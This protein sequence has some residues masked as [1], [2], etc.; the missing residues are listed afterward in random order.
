MEKFSSLQ[1]GFAANFFLAH[2]YK[3][4]I[5]S[6]VLWDGKRFHEESSA[7]LNIFQKMGFPYSLAT[8]SVII[9]EFFRIKIYKYIARNRYKWYGKRESCMIPTDELKY[10]FLE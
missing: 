9:P 3:I 7:I 6:I 1:S 8:A 4:K 5:D 10:K 2:H